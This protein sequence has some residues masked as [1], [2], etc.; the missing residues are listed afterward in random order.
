MLFNESQIR[1]IIEKSLQ[2]AKNN[3]G[4]ISLP[5]TKDAIELANYIAG[6]SLKD[7]KNN[8]NKENLLF[9]FKIN[10]E[11]LNIVY[12]DIYVN[13]SNSINIEIDLFFQK[14]QKKSLPKLIQENKKEFYK[15]VIGKSFNDI[16]KYNTPSYLNIANTAFIGD[17]YFFINKAKNSLQEEG[18]CVLEFNSNSDIDCLKLNPINE[19]YSSLFLEDFFY[20]QSL[21]NNK[22]LFI[23]GLII[24]NII[25]Q[26]NIKINI[27]F[28]LKTINLEFFV[29]YWLYLNNN[30]NN[31]YLSKIILNYIKSLNI[32]QNEKNIFLSKTAQEIHLNNFK[33]II[34]QL[35]LFEKAYDANIFSENGVDLLDLMKSKTS[36]NFF[37]P[38]N[39]HSLIYNY[40]DFLIFI[41]SKSYSNI[42]QQFNIKKQAIFVINKHNKLSVVKSK[43]N[44]IY[45]FNQLFPQQTN[46]LNDFNQIIFCHHSYYNEPNS[47]FLNYF[48]L[49]TEKIYDNI[50][51]NSGEQLLKLK[52]NECFIWQKINQEEFLNKFTLTKIKN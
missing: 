38:D 19:I 8:K 9:N 25:E 4:F 11:N 22:P 33:S 21:P 27:D 13:I 15:P 39:L 43:N 24:K 40:L 12:K 20:Q 29:K 52:N 3:N 23:F 7:Y 37:I 36:T 41:S 10:D 14:F 32:I 49:N 42:V 18:Q 5:K 47:D 28:L 44:Y 31:H 17:S 1:V 48:Y 6:Y 35:H 16:T 2:I 26:T 34:N 46:C 50:F 51:F 45:T 30:N